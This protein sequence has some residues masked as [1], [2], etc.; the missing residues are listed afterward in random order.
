MSEAR[1][2]F[3][4]KTRSGSAATKRIVAYRSSDK[5]RLAACSH[6][7]P[8]THYW[9][10]HFCGKYLLL[11]CE[12]AWGRTRIYSNTVHVTKCT[13]PSPPNVFS[14]PY[15]LVHSSFLSTV[16]TVW[17]A[18]AA[19]FQPSGRDEAV[20]FA[21][22]A[23]ESCYVNNI[24]ILCVCESRDSSS[25][26]GLGLC[27][28]CWRKAASLLRMRFRHCLLRRKKLSRPWV[29]EVSLPTSP[30]KQESEHTL[31]RLIGM[32]HVHKTYLDRITRSSACHILKVYSYTSLRAFTG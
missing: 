10:C 24:L 30:A 8:L 6:L 1:A 3:R 25:N 15:L 2:D 12:T 23:A 13:G 7:R 14:V 19:A 20:W 31:G 28:V 27:P 18:F 29:G 9:V 16:R 26:A 11:G 4:G 32:V 22:L 21:Q 5:K 17:A